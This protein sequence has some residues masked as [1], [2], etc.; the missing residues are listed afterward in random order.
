MGILEYLIKN[1]KHLDH[2]VYPFRMVNMYL[3]SYTHNNW[4]FWY[5][6]GCKLP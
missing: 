5:T 6:V 2:Y 3:C 1:I 4:K